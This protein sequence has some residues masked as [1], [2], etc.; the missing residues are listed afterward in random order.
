MENA[1]GIVNNHVFLRGRPPI[2]EYLGFIVGMAVNGQA[3]DQ[4]QLASSWRDANKYIVNLEAVEKGIADNPTVYNVPD[5]AKPIVAEAISNPLF[6]IAFQMAPAEISMVDLDQLVVY[7]KFINL[8]FVDA[9]ISTL[10]STPSEQDTFRLALGIDRLDP[11]VRSL[12][13]GQNGVSFVSNSGDFRFLGAV[14]LPPNVM[15]P[16][17][18]NG[19]PVAI[20]GLVV[21]YGPNYLS[22][23]KIEN[24]LVLLNGSH[25]AYALKKLGIDRVPCI[26]QHVSTREELEIISPDIHQNPD[27]YLK[28][29]RPPM[30]KDYFNPDLITV[31]PVQAKNKM[32]R[33]QFGLEQSDIPAT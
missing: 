1:N 13:L 33:L 6:H 27:R 17:L 32:V 9:L 21:G 19:K 4:G 2:S 30:L 28:A 3:Y 24:R 15:P 5:T 14:N 20:Y 25:R 7:Q 22:A 16:Q 12:P 11:P 8:G 29:Q 18:L 26:V 23:L 10:G 31:V